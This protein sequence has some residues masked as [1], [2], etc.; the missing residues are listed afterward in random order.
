MKKNKLDLILLIILIPYLT[1]CSGM[2]NALEGNKRSEQSDEFLVKKK[3][4]LQMPPNMNEL[5]TPGGDLEI[6]N[7]QKKDEVKELLQIK[8]SKDNENTENTS[9]LLNNMK[10]KIQ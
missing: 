4:P 5:P 6:N 8:N 1:Y 2:K 3:N 10:K 9:D 7:T